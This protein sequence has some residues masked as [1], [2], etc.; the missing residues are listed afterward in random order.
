M[1]PYTVSILRR[2][3]L[4]CFNSCMLEPRSTGR[5]TEI[6]QRYDHDHAIAKEKYGD[7]LPCVLCSSVQQK[8][9]IHVSETM[10]V[11]RNDYPYAKFDGQIVREHLMIVPRNHKESIGL[12]TAVERTEYLHLLAIYSARGYATMTRSSTDKNRSVPAHFHTH[13]FR[14]DNNLE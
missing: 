7:N 2:C 13:L 14:Y 12:F 9:A 6:Q 3:I 10:L 11:L 4:L 5:S 1:H 8:Q